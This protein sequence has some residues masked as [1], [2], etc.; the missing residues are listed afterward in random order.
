MNENETGWRRYY[1]KDTANKATAKYH[2]AKMR[3]IAVTLH[4]ESDKDVLAQIDRQ[5]NK[6]DYIRRLIRQDISYGMI[7]GKSFADVKL[8]ELPNGNA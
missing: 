2:K 4:N 5:E 7:Y 8:S 6:T 1:N 3:R